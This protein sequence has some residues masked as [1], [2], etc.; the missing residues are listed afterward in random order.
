[1]PEDT[2]TAPAVSPDPGATPELDNGLLSDEE[3]RSIFGDDA[4]QPEVKPEAVTPAPAT[5][6]PATQA[7]EAQVDL[8]A[9]DELDKPEA[10]K[11]DT[12]AA[13][14]ENE[15]LKKV[16]QLLPNEETLGWAID[17]L[18]RTTVASRAAQAGDVNAVLEALPFVRPVLQKA[19]VDYVKANEERI[20]EAFIAKHSPD[21]R[22]PEIDDLKSR[23]S[24]FEQQVASARNQDTQQKQQAEYAGRV[25]AIDTEVNSLFDKVKFTKNETDRKIVTSLFKVALAE[26]PEAFQK[27]ISGDLSVVRPIF[28]KSVKEYVAS[29]KAKATAKPSGETTVAAKPILTGAGSASTEEAPD[30]WARAASYV[31]NIAKNSRPPKG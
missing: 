7:E 11:P 2:I 14:P 29:D 30:V 18:Q 24:A 20:I 8:T 15:Y 5:T 13:T 31:S 26:S 22:N 16:Q 12:P 17:S 1:M 6:D 28:A 19:V 10:P 9:L 27:A 3:L 23:L 25:K 21:K 4:P